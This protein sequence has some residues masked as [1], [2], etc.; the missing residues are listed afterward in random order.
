[1]LFFVLDGWSESSYIVF[2][3][4]RIFCLGW[5]VR[6]F[7]HCFCN[8]KVFFPWMVGQ[9]FLTVPF[10]WN[11]KDFFFGWLVRNFLQ[12]LFFWNSKDF[13]L[14]GWSEI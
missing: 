5:L 9:E 11:S 13:F 12:F 8:S 10:F 6:K 4:L 14:D 3:T 7:L 1:M 2:V